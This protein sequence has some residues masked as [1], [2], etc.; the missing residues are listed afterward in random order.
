[1]RETVGGGGVW[2]WWWCGV[3]WC[4]VVVVVVVVVTRRFVRAWVVRGGVL[5]ACG[6]RA[7]RVSSVVVSNLNLV[8]VVFPTR[9]C[10]HQFKQRDWRH[11]SH[12]L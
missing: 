3:V 9:L 12:R 8:F 4:G 10:C 5:D 11:D 7:L 2:E 1:M 6:R